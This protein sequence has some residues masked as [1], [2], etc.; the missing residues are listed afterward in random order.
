MRSK[1][2][3]ERKGKNTLKGRRG[4]GRETNKGTYRKK[5]TIE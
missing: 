5:S 1:R 2:K 4:G 3:R